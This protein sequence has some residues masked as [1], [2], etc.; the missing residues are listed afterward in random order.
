L[1]SIEEDNK[2]LVRQYIALFVRNDLPTEEVIAP[3]ASGFVYHRPGMPDVTDLMDM[4]QVIEMYRSATTNMHGG[5]EDLVAEGDKVVCRWSGDAT[6]K[7]D[8]LGVAATGKAITVTGIAIYRIVQGKIQEEWDYTDLFGLMQQLGVGP[9]Q[10]KGRATR[11][12]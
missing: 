9:V 10:G 8:L 6:H 4:K 3:L 1:I 2:A 7:G 11:A 12:C 5:I